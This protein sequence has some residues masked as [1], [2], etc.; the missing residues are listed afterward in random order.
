MLPALLI[1]MEKNKQDNFLFIH[2]ILSLILLVLLPTDIKSHSQHSPLYSYKKNLELIQLTKEIHYTNLLIS[3]VT[4][5]KKILNYHI[6]KKHRQLYLQHLFT[7]SA[8]HFGVVFYFI[9]FFLKKFSFYSNYI[10]LIK[11][12]L[13]VITFFLTP[14]PLY[15]IHR[16]A[17]LGVLQLLLN[18]IISHHYFIVILTFAIDYLA[19]NYTSSPFSFTFSF[20]F[21]GAIFS[22]FRIK[23]RNL[24]YTLFVCQLLLAATINPA[25][26]PLFFISGLIYT[27]LFSLFFP[28]FII[29]YLISVPILTPFIH[30]IFYAQKLFFTYLPANYAIHPSLTVPFFLAIMPLQRYRK[31]CLIVLLIISSKEIHNL[32]VYTKKIKLIHVIKE[33]RL[34]IGLRGYI[35]IKKRK[36]CYY[37]LRLNGY[38]KYCRKTD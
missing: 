1:Y 31:F 7:P 18:D 4:G 11:L 15:S 2:L 29:Y 23:K 34:E 38:H 24:F 28:L 22:S 3:Y 9:L 12:L 33:K 8:L 19:G 16:V 32:T 20:L 5:E 30:A 17:L 13:L 37:T 6:R 26:Y 35:A 14:P 36:V 10:Q 25:F 21:L 27:S